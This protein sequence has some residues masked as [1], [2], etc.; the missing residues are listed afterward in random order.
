MVSSND[1]ITNF[2]ITDWRHTMVDVAK[3]WFSYQRLG[4]LSNFS[5]LQL[6]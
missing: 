4:F 5:R 3:F 2:V 1:F 6:I